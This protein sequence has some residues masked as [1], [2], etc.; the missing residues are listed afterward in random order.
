MKPM[1]ELTIFYDPKCGLCTQVRAWM[2]AQPSYLKLNFVGFNHPEAT[3][4]LPELPDLDPAGQIVVYADSG[5]V[6]RGA[7]A[8]ITCLWALR[9]W[10]GWAKKFSRPEWHP[11]VKRLCQLISGNRIKLSH[12]MKMRP[13]EVAEQTTSG[14]DSGSCRL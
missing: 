12:L 10:R 14:C 3:A 13:D 4:I 1:T 5:E 7:E 2:R 8:W 6:Y 9:N 11:F